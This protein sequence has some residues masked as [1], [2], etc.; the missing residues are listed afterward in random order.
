MA[1]LPFFVHEN[2]EGR[3]RQRRR[4]RKYR[5]MNSTP[6]ATEFAILWAEGMDHGWTAKSWRHTTQLRYATHPAGEY[7]TTPKSSTHAPPT[8]TPST[9]PNII[10]QRKIIIRKLVRGGKER[11]TLMPCCVLNYYLWSIQVDAMRGAWWLVRWLRAR[12]RSAADAMIPPS[13][14]RTQRPCAHSADT[15]DR[16]SLLLRTYVKSRLV[17]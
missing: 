11:K 17:F 15:R 4:E 6:A 14:P 13:D 10:E 3:Q 16:P 1:W 5:G 12:R 2:W 8:A 7:W 9:R